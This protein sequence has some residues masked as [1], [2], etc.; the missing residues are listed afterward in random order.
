MCK[1]CDKDIP[2]R[3][4]SSCKDIYPKVN[5]YIIGKNLGDLRFEGNEVT[6]RISPEHRGKG[7]GIIEG[8]GQAGSE[9]HPQ[10]IWGNLSIS[11]DDQLKETC[12]I[13]H[14]HP[15]LFSRIEVQG[16]RLSRPWEKGPHHHPRPGVQRNRMDPQDIKG[17]LCFPGKKGLELFKFQCAVGCNG[18]LNPPIQSADDADF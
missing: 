10:S 6:I 18:H 9:I 12:L 13:Y 4:C 7:I 8:G 17:V 16:R 15:G 11:L 5:F 1:Y 2:Y 14:G 3:I